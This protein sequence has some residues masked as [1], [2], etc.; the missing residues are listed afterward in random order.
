[1]S[2]NP[3]NE[4]PLPMDKW[5]MDWDTMYPCSYDKETTNA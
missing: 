2:F 5:F 3:F 4:K 1:M